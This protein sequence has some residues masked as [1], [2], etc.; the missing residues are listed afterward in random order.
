[1]KGKGKSKR[2][3][4][5]LLTDALREVRHTRSRFLSILVLSALA[6]AILS[7]LRTTAPDM[8]YTADNY[9]DET[10]LMDGYVLSTLG[11]V[12]ED[13][14]ALAAAPADAAVGIHDDGACFHE[15]LDQS[16][17]YG[18]LVDCLAGRYDQKTDQGM[19]FPAL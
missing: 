13:L 15:G 19:D 9:Y 12:E 18:F 3:K 1:M 7:G 17:L 8:E 16:F 14:D 11:I 5:R 6:V 2:K 10:H 4:N